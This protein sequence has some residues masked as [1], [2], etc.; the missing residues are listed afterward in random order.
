MLVVRL[1]RIAPIAVVIV[2]ALQYVA[3]AVHC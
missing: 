1:P 3:L 2:V